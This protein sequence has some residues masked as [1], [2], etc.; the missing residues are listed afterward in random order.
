[1]VQEC[2]R[3]ECSEE[4]K[5]RCAK[6]KR[7]F[8]CS[9]ECQHKDWRTHKKECK[10]LP[11]IAIV[12]IPGKGKGV[13]AKEHIA[14]GTLIVSER[15]RV[16]LPAADDPN[17]DQAI[18]GLSEED[19]SFILS[20]PGPESNPVRE[21]FEHFMHCVGDDGRDAL[22]LSTTICRVNHTCIS[23]NWGPNAAYS[24]NDKLKEAVLY[25]TEEIQDEQEIEVSYMP[26]PSPLGFLLN[27]YDFK[28]TCPGCTRPAAER[29]ASAQRIRAYNDWARLPL[30]F[31]Q[32][33]PLEMLEDIEEQLLTICREGYFGQTTIQA[34]HA[35]RLCAAFSD[36]AS[37][38]QW[39]AMRRDS[40]VERRGRTWPGSKKA[41]RLAANPEIFE[42]WGAC[43]TFKLRGPS[44]ELH[45]CFYKPKAAV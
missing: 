42:D 23:P 45:E 34:D 41:A 36:A 3:V 14:R 39:G 15:P 44:K 43:G 24:W 7:Y 29:F 28:C 32:T 13:I 4:G 20:F 2:A 6:C 40:V 16:I 5:M 22:G 11:R 10:P 21:R 27:K 26:N 30:H 37:A 1:M 33:H 17:L 9:A 12:D 25:A 19:L 35:F 18:A 31:G 38:Q 8:Y